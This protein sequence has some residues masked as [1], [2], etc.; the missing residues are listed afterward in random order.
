MYSCLDENSASTC[1]SCKKYET[2]VFFKVNTENRVVIR[3]VDTGDAKFVSS[4][5]GC[6]IAD[7]KNWICK[8]SWSNGN[9][10]QKYIMSDGIYTNIGYNFYGPAIEFT[11]AK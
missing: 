4:L 7:K 6:N 5:E 9:L 10:F 8:S 11:C 1:S 2:K 3:T